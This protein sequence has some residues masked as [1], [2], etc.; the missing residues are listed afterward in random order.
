MHRTYKER[1]LELLA[2]AGSL[3]IL[4]S[5]LDSGADAFYIGGKNLNMRLHRRDLNFTDEELVQ[6]GK[7]CRS[8]GKK[9]YITVNKL[10]GAEDLEP[11][12]A[13]LDFIADAVQPDAI[14]IQ[15]LA[16]PAI[17][18]ERGLN[19]AM[20]ASVM[21]NAHN[22]AGI[23]T[24]S[25]LGITRVVISRECS[26]EDTKRLHEATGM[27]LEY[28]AHGDLCAA[29]GSQCLY[30]GMLFGLSSNRGLCMKP[31]R[32]PFSAV[33]N[34][35][36]HGSGFPLA[37]RD[38]CLYL[39]LKTAAESGISAFKIEGRMRSAD[40]LK[41]IISAYARSLDRLVESSRE[42]TEAERAAYNPTDGYKELFANRMRDFTTAF[43]YGRPGSSMLNTRWEG[44][45]KF[46]STGKVFSHAVPEPEATEKEIEKIIRILRKAKRSIPDL[47]AGALHSIENKK[48][49]SN[50]R[51]PQLAVR[52]DTTAMATVAFEAG[53]DVAIISGDPYEPVTD[54]IIPVDSLAELRRAFPEKVICLSLP[55]MMD[56]YEYA[57]WEAA[58]QER[59]GLFDELYISHLGSEERFRDLAP[60]LSGDSSLNVLN[61]KAANV[62]AS[63]GLVS[64]CA[65]IE[66]GATDL[67][68][69]LSQSTI[70][71]ELIVHGRPTAMYIGLDMDTYIANLP[72]ANV[73][74][75]S[76]ETK[77]AFSRALKFGDGIITLIDAKGGPHPLIRDCRDRYHLLPT[78][79]ISLKPLVPALLEAGVARFRLE[80]ALYDAVTLRTLCSSWRALL[81]GTDPATINV[82]LE[83]EGTWLGALGVASKPHR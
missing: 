38:M 60:R 64:I 36:L 42:P 54:A 76:P 55:R 9:L 51:Q 82:P 13:F 34:G 79:T 49:S 47:A 80:G 16:V 53:A 52:L 44:T 71:V 46:Y 57:E 74:E 26:F 72:K 69:L 41:P 77:E 1:K 23:Q 70:P 50:D 35:E 62:W 22:T 11:A 3:S 43:A 66:V 75:A 81:D 8:H 27:E 20:H 6:A 18:A 10:M 21:M 31:C 78:K 4:Q 28:F 24:L 61:G 17:V 29:H 40:Y 58:L 48:S 33:K 56:D 2:P 37:V 39:D 14:L 73:E 59:A 67:V 65:S 68:A 12:P 30:S 7:L 5:L 45:G 15:D 32:W 25:G 63:R 19:L 83:I